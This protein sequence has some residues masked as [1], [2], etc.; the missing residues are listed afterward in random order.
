MR[1]CYTVLFFMNIKGLILF[2]DRDSESRSV[3]YLG[4]SIQ[5]ILYFH[6]ST[7]V[8]QSTNHKLIYFKFNHYSTECLSINYSSSIHQLLYYPFLCSEGIS[9]SD[10]QSLMG[11]WAYIAPVSHTFYFFIS[12][13]CLIISYLFFISYAKYKKF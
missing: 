11:V 2:H 13:K 7:T 6:M 5:K 12:K 9:A 1:I 4:I 10:S 3:T 8:L